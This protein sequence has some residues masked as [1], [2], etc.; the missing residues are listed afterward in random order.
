MNSRSHDPSDVIWA[1][2]DDDEALH[3]YRELATLIDGG[4]FQL[5]LSSQFEVIKLS[6]VYVET[7]DN[8]RVSLTATDAKI[9][10][11]QLSRVEGDA[12]QLRQL[13]QNLRDNAC[14]TEIVRLPLDGEPS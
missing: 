6:D 7:C 3:R 4:I 2:A 12:S 11:E 14:W 10:C 5:D 13:F 8:L 9:T 1:T